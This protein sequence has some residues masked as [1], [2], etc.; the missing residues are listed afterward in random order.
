MTINKNLTNQNFQKNLLFMPCPHRFLSY[1]ID[2]S[3]FPNWEFD[4]L[5]IGTFNPS[6]QFIKSDPASYFYGRTKNNYFWDALPII[7]KKDGLRDENKEKWIEFLRNNKIGLTDLIINVHDAEESNNDHYCLLKSMTDVNL[8]KFKKIEFNTERIISLIETNKIS[9]IYITN[10]TSPKLFENE[11]ANIELA[12]K[13]NHIIFKRL[14]TPS[15][16]A[17]FKIPKGT[18]IIDGI[19]NDWKTKFNLLNI[20]SSSPNTT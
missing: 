2:N 9:K 17:R 3:L 5:I 20:Q 15:S 16:S 13:K 1:H 8:A 7:L 12:C 18:K 6:W 10:K 4:T 19:V 11:F 14:L